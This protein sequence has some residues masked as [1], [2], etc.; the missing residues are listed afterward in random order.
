MPTYE[1]TAPNGKKYRVT[2]DGTKDE[3]LAH[4]QSTY[5]AV[6]LKT[7]NPAEY[8]PASKEY[9]A[10][11][12][13]TAG[14][15]DQDLFMAGAGKAVVD[16]GRGIKQ[17]GAWAMDKVSPQ[18]ELSSLITGKDTSRL[19]KLRA[20]QD[21][22]N[23]R[24]A[25]LMATGNGLGGNIT[26]SVASILLPGGAMSKAP[27]VIGKVGQAIV[28]P[29]SIKAA[30]AVGAGL[31]ALQ[32]VGTNESRTKNALIGAGTSAATQ[33]VVKGLGKLAQPV[34][35]ALTPVDESAVKTLEQAGVRLDAAQKTGSE[36]LSQVKRFLGD[37]PIT[38]GGQ[39]KQAEKTASSFTRAALKTI[40]ENSDAADET[41]VANAFDR[42]GNEFDRIAAAN[43]I[44]TDNQLLNDIVQVTQRA[45][46]ELI[47]PAAAVIKK[48]AD[49][50]I[51]KAASGSIKGEAYASLKGAL[52]RISKGQDQQLG[53]LARELRGY[54]D[55]ALERSAA[56]G[57][58]AALREAR[59]QYRN[60]QG[61]IKA[62][63]PDGNVSPSKLYNAMNTVAYGGKKQMATG[64]GTDL[65]KLAKAGARVIPE[66]MPNSGTTPRAMLQ[67]AV[68]ALAGGAYGFSQEGDMAGAAKYAA[69]GIGAP[70][71]AQKAINNPTAANYLARGIQSPAARGLL[72]APQQEALML[73][74]IPAAGLLSL[75]AEQ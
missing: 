23:K 20:E 55:D 24:D 66:R 19:G 7:Q 49:E 2:G 45:D 64:K 46:G 71:L 68:P 57:D 26:G 58:M 11:Y 37:N 8:D 28:N 50:I 31:G 70:W 48:Q 3:A 27:G 1:I 17:I 44:K 63:K 18:R 30:A 38:A 47:S 74:Q 40:G 13:A 36:R 9:Q 69:L 60:I 22:V 43:P 54:L 56:P 61:I 53:D 39:V 52:D 25:A 59:K 34:K 12:G 4:F 42:I 32:P 35:N 21:E 33:T 15:S 29:Q 73:R 6:D 65:M 51:D 16:A 41:T 5:K 72:M 67:A 75:Q 10:K 14:M 62:V